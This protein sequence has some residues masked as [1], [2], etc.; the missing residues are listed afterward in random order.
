MAR[1][2]G[3]LLV[4]SVAAGRLRTPNRTHAAETTNVAASMAMAALGS[5]WVISRPPPAKPASCAD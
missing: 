4:L 1:R 5:T 3:G 2:K